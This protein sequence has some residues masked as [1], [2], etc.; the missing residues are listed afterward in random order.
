MNT[1]IFVVPQARLQPRWREA[2]GTITV[3][4]SAAAAIRQARFGSLIWIDVT[5]SA[6]IASLRTAR[7]ELPLIAMSLNPSAAEGLAAFEAGVRAYCHMLGAPE[8]LR[9]VAAVVAN[10]GLWLGT[11]LMARAAAA[12]ARLAPPPPSDGT[13]PLDRL[14]PR[15]R[16]VALQVAGGAANK[17]VARR[18]NIT[19]RTVKAHMGAIFDKLGVQDRL[20]LVLLLRGAALA[21]GMSAEGV[22]AP[23]PRSNIRLH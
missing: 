5:Q 16:D 1:H 11:E 22:D 8:M 23:V 21:A 17:E 6:W 20:H 13:S 18:L 12:V 3:V 4:G 7:P 19:P 15:E 14:T 2:F 9:Q 10:G